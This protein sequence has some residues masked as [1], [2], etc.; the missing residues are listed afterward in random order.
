M[1]KRSRGGG[2]TTELS[3]M[4]NPG[5]PVYQQYQGVGKD[6]MGDFTRPGYMSSGLPGL[7]GGRRH[8]KRRSRGGAAL[9][10][11]PFTELTISTP[12][13]STQLK[14]VQSGGRYEIN[15]GF[16]DLF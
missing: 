14:P 5:N 6:C 2:Y 4:I 10:V 1:V 16:L 7:R 15:P 9:G 3:N 12:G 13:V 8:S 11:A